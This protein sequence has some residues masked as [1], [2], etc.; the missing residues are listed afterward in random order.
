MTVV[1]WSLLSLL[2]PDPR[3]DMVGHVVWLLVVF[4]GTRQ[5]SPGIF[6]IEFQEAILQQKEGGEKL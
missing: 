4:R 1:P 3:G 2:K 5:C 6:Q